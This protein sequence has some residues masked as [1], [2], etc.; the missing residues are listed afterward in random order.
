MHCSDLPCCYS[1]P[2]RACAT[3]SRRKGSWLRDNLRQGVATSTKT[4]S[5]CDWTCTPYNCIGMVLFYESRGELESPRTVPRVISCL[6][7]DSA[8]IY[9]RDHVRLCSN[10]ISP[11][12]TVRC[13]FLQLLLILLYLYHFQTLACF[14]VHP[15]QTPYDSKKHLCCLDMLERTRSV[16]RSWSD[17]LDLQPGAIRQV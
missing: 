4:G 9:S 2:S 3:S 8:R 6:E 1:V 17:T 10:Y 5:R 15:L 13:S 12:S 16:V 11:K 14:G 7:G